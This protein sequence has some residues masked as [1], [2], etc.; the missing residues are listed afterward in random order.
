[1]WYSE[2][3]TVNR[4]LYND[5]LRT[6]HRVRTVVTVYDGS[7]VIE[8]EL[9]V[10]DGQVDVDS[11]ADVTRS[12]SLTVADPRLKFTFAPMGDVYVDR[13]VGVVYGVLVPDVGWVDVPVFRGPVTGYSRQGHQVNIEAAGKESLMM[14]PVKQFSLP[15]PTS[16]FIVAYIENAARA[17]GETKFDLGLASNRK[18]P[19]SFDL[20]P[21]KAREKGVWWY[22]KQL[23][24]SVNLELLY[25]GRGFLRLR[26]YRPRAIVHNFTDPLAP[27]SVG[28]NLSEVR[29]IVE[30]YG[31]DDKD[32]D[33]LKARV[34]LATSHPLSAQS[35]G[36]AGKPRWLVERVKLD[37]AKLTRVS[38]A[39]IAE[40]MLRQRSTQAVDVSFDSIPI[41]HIEGGDTCRLV[42]EGIDQEFRARQFSIPLGPASMSVGYTRAQPVAKFRSKRI[43]IPARTR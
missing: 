43:P 7:E 27:P 15:N 16:R 24:D 10:A 22:L 11:T 41:P 21:H 23:A 8:H 42:S 37:N 31:K 2:L 5:T 4:Q 35:L 20:D 12:L 19:K 28:F 32:N 38:A 18:V 17:F 13:H 34:V 3:T 14:P 29:N 30:V 39:K 6:S 9:N 33:V 26:P 25:D 40:R 1:M 36:R